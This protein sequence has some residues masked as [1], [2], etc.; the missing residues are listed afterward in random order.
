MLFLKGHILHLVL[1][2]S[3]AVNYLVFGIRL[4]IFVRRHL[5]TA[6]GGYVL[7]VWSI[8]LRH[9][10]DHRQGEYE[11]YWPRI[12]GTVPSIVRKT[13]DERPFK[14]EPNG[15]LEDKKKTR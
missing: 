10:L 8:W 6:T 2:L 13:S 12:I 7:I 1:G 15:S 14:S 4:I 11:L 3:F 5:M 9:C